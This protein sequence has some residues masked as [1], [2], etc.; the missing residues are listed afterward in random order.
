M[1]LKPRVLFV[2]LVSGA[3]LAGWRSNRGFTRT[4]VGMPNAQS[5]AMRLLELCNVVMLQKAQCF[6]QIDSFL[7]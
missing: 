1:A 5:H 2:D 7:R 3:V 6:T 4:L